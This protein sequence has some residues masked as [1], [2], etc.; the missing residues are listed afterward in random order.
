MPLINNNNPIEVG[1]PIELGQNLEKAFEDNL[2]PALV[3]PDKNDTIA[4]ILAEAG[5]GTSNVKEPDSEHKKLR[6]ILDQSGASV[7]N[8]SKTIAHVMQKGKFDASRLKAAELV[9]DL[10]GLRDKDGGMVKQ[11]VF[12]FLIKDSTVNINQIFSPIRTTR[13]EI[14]KAADSSD[15]SDENTIDL[16]P[17]DVEEIEEDE[18]SEDSEESEDEDSED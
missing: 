6:K 3:D 14:I 13:E 17:A 8:A 15:S 16:D 18:D 10:H 7:I 4:S 2:N 1:Q 12:Q 5:I 11:P 9:F